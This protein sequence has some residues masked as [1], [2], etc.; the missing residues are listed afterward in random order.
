MSRQTLYLIRHG[1]TPWTLSRQHT[2]RTDISLTEKGKQEA[3]SLKNKLQ[4]IPFNALFCS[5]LKRAQE[6]CLLSGLKNPTIA[7]ELAEWDYGAYEGKTTLEIRE[8][9]PKWNLFTQGAPTGESP[10]DIERRLLSFLKQI[11]PIEGTI[12]I[13]S[14]GH[15]LRSL[16]ALWLGLPIRNAAC[17]VLST[18]SLSIL[19]YEREHRALHLWNDT[20]HLDRH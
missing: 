17:F 20:S 10:Q 3:S 8:T 18:A 11:A 9:A 12:A 16:A 13:F 15:L 5:P 19:G 1:E 7:P 14:H 4:N 2:G 6:T